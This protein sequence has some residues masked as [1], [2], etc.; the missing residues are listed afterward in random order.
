MKLLH[1]ISFQ[2]LFVLMTILL[3]HNGCSKDEDIF[4]QP[5]T[6]EF[7]VLKVSQNGKTLTSGADNLGVVGSMQFVFSHSI[8]TTAFEQAFTLSPGN[9]LTASYDQSNSI[10]TITFEEPLEYETS[11]T[12]T[13]PKGTYGSGGESSNADFVFS[14][15]TAPFEPPAVSLSADINKL[16]EGESITLTA[17]L[18]RS[19]I[20]DAAVSLEFSG[21]AEKDTDYEVSTLVLNIPAGST[22]ATAIISGIPDGTMEGEEDIVIKL[23][24][25]VNCVAYSDGLVLSL[26]DL[27]PALELKGA[28]SLKIGGTS[29]NGRAI[30]LRVL[31]D[32]PQLSIYGLGIANNGGGSD[33]REIDFPEGTASKGDDI[34]LI[35]DIDLPNVS[36][37]FGECFQDFEQVIETGGLNFNG[38]DPFELYNGNTVIESFGDVEL[39]GTGLE[40]EY[41]GT[42]AWKINGEW[43]YAAVDCS[44]NTATNAESLCAYPFCAPLQLQGVSSLR[45][46]GSGT[47]G[48]KFVQ[49]RANR[50]IA[51]LSRFGVGVAN[52][53]GGTDGIEFTFPEISAAEGDQILLARE[54][55]TIA[56]YL[57]NCINQFDQV[58]EVSAM[59]QNGDDAI[60]LFDGET[61]IETYGDAN[62]DG[63]GQFWEYLNTWAFKTANVWNVADADCAQSAT[64]NS[65][66]PCP[67]GF[68]N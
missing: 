32:I 14:F 27:P 12:F 20:K 9:P 47:N 54:P 33:G 24:N 7:R 6:N 5:I 22:S 51:D 23:A 42:W 2:H 41:T 50:D 28:M 13:L 61:V 31:E 4:N 25:P 37:Y 26:G 44:A 59:S 43:E 35:R 29:T 16:F 1:K 40:W 15:S 66:S 17:T 46:D 34:L 3:L 63:T 68:C 55:A 45:W 56:A 48:G 62:V 64:T 36:S 67:Y 10:V 30:H 38:D 52:N 49:I 8:N 39:D 53:G 19:I 60:E 18:A 21:S 57:G 58:F 11:Y 65:I